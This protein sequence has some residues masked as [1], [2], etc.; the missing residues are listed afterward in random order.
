MKII[1]A[2]C[3]YNNGIGINNTIPW[4]LK[5]D[6]AYFKRITTTLPPTYLNTSNNTLQ[7][8]NM[9]VMG[10]KTWDSIPEKNRPL[11]NRINIVLSNN[12]D[13][14][15][16][17]DIEKYKDTYVKH[18]F[19][20]I[21]SVNSLNSQYE[22]KFGVIFIIGGSSI[23]KE[24]LDS[25]KIDEV[26]VTEVYNKFTCDTFFPV[27]Y[28]N[29]KLKSVSKF[30][31]EDGIYFRYLSYA[32]INLI[33]L[34]NQNDIILW[35][36]HEENQYLDCL[37]HIIETGLETNDRTQVGTYSIFGEKFEYNLEDTFP[38][39][40]TKKIFFRGIVE[41]L[42]LY[43]SG[44]TD[45]GILNDKKINIWDGNTT[46]EFLDKRGL[47]HY[48]END[49][50]ETYGFNFRHYG[51]EYK[52]CKD[53]YTGQGFDQIKNVIDLIKTDPNSRRII[54][55]LWNPYTNHKAAL[56]SCL[57]FYQFY[58]DTKNKKL[59]LQ[60][61]IRSS[62]FFLANNWNTLTG[63]LIVHMICNLKDIDLTPGKLKVIT[64]DTHIYKTHL[65]QVQENLTRTPKPFPKLV[66]KEEKQNIEDYCYGDFELIGYHP[67]KNISAEMAV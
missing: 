9:V 42:L 10:R 27:L 56:P 20:E 54:I 25:K 12:R 65:E 31:E 30:M 37:K 50:G 14:D 4:C 15:F 1:V 48:P 51:G 57:C 59:N 26:I 13:Q 64:G 23:Y 2:Y 62:D 41:E 35:K 8:K 33:N 53:D 60:I 3:K 47:S 61:Y 39:L 24:A 18:S 66:I 5:K 58:V 29:Y 49:M 67:Y 19:D 7:P 11:K 43:I 34:I 36:N 45:N 6:L 17:D 40:T 52:T 22:Y 32:N 46:R 55:N 63:A 38:A 28:N 21:I 44:K 16:I